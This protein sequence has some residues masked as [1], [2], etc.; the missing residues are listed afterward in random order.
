MKK[1]ANLKIVQ[2]PPVDE[3]LDT[4]PSEAAPPPTEASPLK[5]RSIGLIAAAI[6]G[7]IAA[8]GAGAFWLTGR[9][10]AAVPATGSLTVESV[11]AGVDVMIDGSPHGKTPVTI[12]LIEGTHRLVLQ[13]G[14]RTQ[15][16]PL[17]IR[18]NTGVVHHVAW[19]ADDDSP[20]ASAVTGSLRVVSEPSAATVTV[21][22]IDRGTTPLTIA[23]LTVGQHD[24]VVRGGGTVQRRTL[25]IESNT[26]TSLVITGV[27]SGTPSGWLA[28][29]APAP[30]RIFEGG[31]FV[32]STESDQIM[33]PAG[34][35]SFDFSSDALGFKATRTVKIAAG[36]TASVALLLPRV[37]VALNA[38]PWAQVWVDGQALGAT[39]IGDFTTTIGTH[40]VIFRHP[41]FGERRVTTLV[42]LKEPARVAIDMSKR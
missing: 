5:I 8:I 29:S 33:L 34:E 26:T 3:A 10:S 17:T 22:S 25:Q 28:A 32:G 38:T 30:L 7:V 12:A 21:D 1:D 31:K 15:E 9:T 42:T 18:P 4:F 20:A 41:Q 37:A 14:A 11:P 24:I 13:R 23:G 36:Q 16:F 27:E 35:H 19:P 2:I 39:P 6:I 40:E